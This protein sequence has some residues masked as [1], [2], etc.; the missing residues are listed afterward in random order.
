MAQW[1]LQRLSFFLSFQ[2]TFFF[3]RGP[4]P[5]ATLPLGSQMADTAPEGTCCYIHGWQDIKHLCSSIGPA[6]SWSSFWLYRLKPGGMVSVLWTL[7]IPRWITCSARNEKV[8]VWKIIIQS[9]LHRMTTYNSHNILMRLTQLLPQ[10]TNKETD[11]KTGKQRGQAPGLNS[12]SLWL[13]SGVE[14]G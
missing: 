5:E 13:E 2:S 4:H 9:P 12:H 1:C 14:P 6:W 3:Y 8:D 10:I 11:V 7:N